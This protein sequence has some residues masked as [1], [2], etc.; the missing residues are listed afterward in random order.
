M[1]IAALCLNIAI[2][3]PVIFGLATG[4][5]DVAFGPDTDARRILTCVYFGIATLSVVLIGLHVGGHDWAVPM[6]FALFGVQIIY[7]LATVATVGLASPVV[8][9][10]VLVVGVQI[11]AIV[12]W[13]IPRG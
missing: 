10:N 4:G 9:T 6:T 1:L 13:S 11:A 5:M 12:A 8:L 3:L 7:K 2:L